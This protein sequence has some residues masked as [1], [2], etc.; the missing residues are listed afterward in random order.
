MS[1]LEKIFLSL[2]GLLDS[3]LQK[4]KFP[5]GESLYQVQ[6]RAWEF[7]EEKTK[8][9]GNILVVTHKIVIHMLILKVFSLNLDRLG[10]IKKFI[11]WIK[12]Q[13][14]LL[15]IKMVNKVYYRR[16]MQRLIAQKIVKN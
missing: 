13:F 10:K 8:F 12:D 14:Q 3:I 2:F 11:Q 1:K 6:K 5:E 7:L 16:F 4:I 15:N 9:A